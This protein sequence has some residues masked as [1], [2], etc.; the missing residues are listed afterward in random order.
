MIYDNG[1]TCCKVEQIGHC[2][3]EQNGQS[4]HVCTHWGKQI[5]DC[6]KDNLNILDRKRDS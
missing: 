6:S 3:V 4:W 1:C 2:R 5:D